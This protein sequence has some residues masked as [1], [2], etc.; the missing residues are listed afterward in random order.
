MDD[1]LEKLGKRIAAKRR[2]K[3]LSQEELA[4]LANFHRNYIGY[5]ERGEFDFRIKTI[6]KVADA[7]NCPLDV[8][9]KNL[10]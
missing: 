4:E 7:L 9:F 6:K 10:K 2:R 8:L 1:F 3:K 5:I